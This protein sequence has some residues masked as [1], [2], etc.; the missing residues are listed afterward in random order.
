MSKLYWRC[1]WANR[2]SLLGCSLF[3]LA[4]A[5]EIA[6]QVLAPGPPLK[7]PG[8]YF[9]LIALSLASVGFGFNMAT[10]LGFATVRQYC[11][12]MD[13]LESEHYATISNDARYCNRIGHELALRDYAK[14]QKR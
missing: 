14:K 3:C 9:S 4:C 11:R 12:T 10:R 2:V 6:H 8:I 13:I 7:T 1:V 5:I